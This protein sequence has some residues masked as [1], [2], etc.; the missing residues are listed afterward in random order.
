MTLLRHSS[1][2]TQRTRRW[3]L[4]LIVTGVILLA[5]SGS[6]HALQG[7]W[8]EQE[9]AAYFEQVWLQTPVQA[10]LDLPFLTENQGGVYAPGQTAV[11]F[12]S[13]FQ[14]HEALFVRLYHRMNGM[15]EAYQ[16]RADVLGQVVLSRSLSGLPGEQGYTPTGSLWFEVI[17][18]SGMEQVYPFRLKMDEDEGATPPTKGVYP[19][20]AVQGSV[21]LLWCS[22]QKPG[23]APV[24]T[25]SVD[26]KPLRP[27]SLRLK[28]YPV[29]SDGLL[30]AS[31]TISLDDPTGEWA[32]YLNACKFS[33]SVQ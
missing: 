26:G 32:V 9:R 3:A 4:L 1:L 16:S 8:T 10:G 25:A 29:A 23:E 21:V 20:S 28:H 33:F 15:L 2:H 6:L 11:A 14:P 7:M 27:Q 30:L 12:V 18:L 22:G 5:V 17:G 31:L 13:G 24:V 19:E